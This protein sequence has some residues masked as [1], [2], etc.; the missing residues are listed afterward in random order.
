MQEVKPKSERHEV[1]KGMVEDEIRY[2]RAERPISTLNR[3]SEEMKELEEKMSREALAL[4]QKKAHF[5]A[6]SKPKGRSESVAK[7][8]RVESDKTWV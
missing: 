7:V 3:S 4:V 1:Q 5:D 2:S 8:G 6:M